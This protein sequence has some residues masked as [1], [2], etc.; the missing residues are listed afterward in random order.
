MLGS[1]WCKELLL[2]IP[3]IPFLFHVVESKPSSALSGILVLVFDATTLHQSDRKALD[4]VWLTSLMPSER[5]GS[6]TWQS[7]TIFLVLPLQVT[8]SRP[9]AHTNTTILRRKYKNFYS[10]LVLS[11]LSKSLSL[12]F[13]PPPCFHLSSVSISL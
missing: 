9:D 7:Q 6:R 12:L 1:P 2:L 10:P 8:S 4:E 5:T 13:S 3:V 11:L